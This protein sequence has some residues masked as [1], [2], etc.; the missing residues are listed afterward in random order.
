VRTD[1]ERF[2]VEGSAAARAVAGSSAP[3]AI[4]KP[5]NKQTNTPIHLFKEGLFIVN[6]GCTNRN[7]SENRE[8][9]LKLK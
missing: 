9:D 3:D 4:V 5:A 2:G 1:S 7:E 8:Q 6:Y